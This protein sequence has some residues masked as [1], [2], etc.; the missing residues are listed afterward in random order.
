MASPGSTKHRIIPTIAG[1]QLIAFRINTLA[2]GGLLQQTHWYWAT[3]TSPA[4]YF[5]DYYSSDVGAW[6][7]QD[8]T[9]G[10]HLKR[11]DVGPLQPNRGWGIRF[12]MDVAWYTNGV[13]TRQTSL[14]VPWTTGN[15]GAY[16]S[17]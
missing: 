1:N 8:A 14:G 2:N 11:V 6:Q 13:V 16:C 7:F 4:G 17:N 12:T 15:V 10:Q 3:A 5:A 9:T